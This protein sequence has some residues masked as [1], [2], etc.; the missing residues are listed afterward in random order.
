MPIVK[1]KNYYVTV[2]VVRASEE[3]TF[4]NDIIEYEEITSK[5]VMEFQ[6][7]IKSTIF[8]QE[9]DAGG[10]KILNVVV[11]AFSVLGD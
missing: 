10:N 7:K 5:N 9:R 4:R 6:E 3:M 2:I 8:G 11:S 1:I